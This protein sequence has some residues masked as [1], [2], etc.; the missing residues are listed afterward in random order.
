MN[1]KPCCLATAIGSMPHSDPG[2][3]LAVI[4]KSIPAAPI[5]PQLPRLGLREQMEIQYSEA[6]PR[7]VIDEV[8]ERILFDTSGDTSEDL[9]AFYEAYMAA[10]ESGDYSCA[11]ISPAFSAGIPAMERHLASLGAKLPFF[12][13]Q[14][15]GPM[16]FALTVVDENKR[17]IYY[18]EE[19]RDVVVK[20]LS[21]KARWQIEKFKP[22]A[23]RIICFIDEPILSG[24]GS[25]TYVS[26]QR[27]D[28]TALLGEVIDAIHAAGALAGVHCCGN[29]EWPLLVDAGA[30]IVNF[31]AYDFGE[32]VA[33]YPEQMKRHIETNGN[34]LAW[35]I[36]P[37]SQAIRGEKAESLV[38]RLESLMENLAGKTGIDKQQILEQAFIT[39][40]CGTGSLEVS[41]SERVF[42]LLRET[43]RAMQEKHGFAPLVV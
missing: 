21:M 38:A 1:F 20:S 23:E 40:S 29:T 19:F 42:E 26:I 5:W 31:D 18:N 34:A 33:L 2:Q 7:V 13:G 10:E 12:K 36:V 28:V 27:E 8:K 15:T 35:G 17:A 4:M 39:P 6:M 41:D 37:T 30:D 43:S 32:T 24:F 14:V 22:F 11:A 25:S 9:A 3:A 16:S